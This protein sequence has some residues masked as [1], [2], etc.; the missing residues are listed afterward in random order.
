MDD[1]TRIVLAM[2]VSSL[3]VL[4]EELYDNAKGSISKKAHDLVWDAMQ[5]SFQE[6]H[7][8]KPSDITPKPKLAVVKR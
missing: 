8:T 2:V 3:S 6:L 7:L 1:K 5:T 4:N